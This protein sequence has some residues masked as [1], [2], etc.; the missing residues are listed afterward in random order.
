MRRVLQA[1]SDHATGAAEIVCQVIPYRRGCRSFFTSARGWYVVSD[2]FVSAYFFWMVVRVM[3]PC[4]RNTSLVV[5]IA[6]HQRSNK[7]FEMESAWIDIVCRTGTK[8]K[9]A[10]STPSTPMRV[11][12]DAKGSVA[13]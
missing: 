5:C 8:T 1:A 12:T 10:D 6:F 4:A 9:P 2:P 3:T 7:S 11:S 13:N